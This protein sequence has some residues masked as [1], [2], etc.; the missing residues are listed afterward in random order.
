MVSGIPLFDFMYNSFTSDT[1]IY[2][3]SIKKDEMAFYSNKKTDFL[4]TISEESR[5]ILGYKCIKASRRNATH[6][7]IAWFTN[8][9]P[10][11]GGPLKAE[12]LPG[13]VLEY[14]YRNLDKK[15]AD[16]LLI[17]NKIDLYSSLNVKRV[18]SDAIEMSFNDYFTEQ[19]YFLDRGTY[20]MIKLI[21]TTDVKFDYYPEN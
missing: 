15:D 8:E 3:G 14:S 1:Y 6:E 5:T 19:V 13:L 21:G 18:P 20:R 16:L 4:W 17:A 2:A 12:G 11:K 10:L 9:L 7:L